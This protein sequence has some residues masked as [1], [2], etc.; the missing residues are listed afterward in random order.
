M[1]LEYGIGLLS[2]YL[3]WLCFLCVCVIALKQLGGFGYAGQMGNQSILNAKHAIAKGWQQNVNWLLQITVLVLLSRLIVY[4][5]AYLAYRAIND[6]G[7]DFADL[8]RHIWLRWDSY[9]Y[10]NLADNGYVGEGQDRYL[11][12]FYPLYPSLMAL[13]KGFIA[14]TFYAGV[15]VSL[16]NLVLSC[17]LLFKLMLLEFNDEETAWRAVKYLLLFPFSF[18]TAI[19]YT[20]STF[21]LM[22]IACFY[23]MRQGYWWLAGGFGLLAALT[24]NQGVLLLAPML[25][26]IV[27]QHQGQWPS[28]WRQR[29]I[30]A[31]PKLL[32]ASLIPTGILIYL[33]LNKWVSGDW[34]RFLVYQQENWYQGFGYFAHNLAGIFNRI[35][36]DNHNL[37]MGTWWPTLIGFFAAVALIMSSM[38]RVPCSYII[39]SLCYLV[40]SYSPTWLLSGP[41]YLMGMFP[42][43]I[44]IA[45]GA[46]KH[47]VLECLLDISLGMLLALFIILFFRSGVL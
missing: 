27:R 39:Y 30:F 33:L 32:A 6:N 12:V 15:A 47:K 1:T 36:S 14:D 41:R 18:F 24:R 45:L 43:F 25:Y 35:Q 28:N 20:E 26:E 23:Y 7:G 2:V 13:M 38:R 46:K 37:A 11:L 16:V 22:S 31:L 40:I 19:V 17:F 9:H 29:V 21:L 44:F 5:V 42:L 34:F 8:F 3:V 4:M 10:I